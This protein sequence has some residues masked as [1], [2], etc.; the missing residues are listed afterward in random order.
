MS[1]VVFRDMACVHA[2]VSARLYGH[3]FVLGADNLMTRGVRHDVQITN[4][5]SGISKLQFPT[6]VPVKS[7]VRFIV[8]LGGRGIGKGRH[9]DT[10]QHFLLGLLLLYN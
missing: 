2:F 1:F 8:G 7:R 9:M 4:I 5:L 3:L 6:Q 10:C